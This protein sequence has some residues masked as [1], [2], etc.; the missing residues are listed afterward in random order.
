MLEDK[1]AGRQGG[2]T[3]RGLDGKG[4]GG[5]GGW[6]LGEARKI[7]IE[8]EALPALLPKEIV[9]I[10]I[11][12]QRFFCCKFGAILVLNLENCAFS[13]AKCVLI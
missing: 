6:E 10:E 7:K 8:A 12:F 9:T 5:Q 1:G 11:D 4:A 13:G 2:W 3:A